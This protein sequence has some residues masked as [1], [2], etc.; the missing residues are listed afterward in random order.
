MQFLAREGVQI[1]KRS[2]WWQ[3]AAQP[4]SDQPDFI[5]GVVEVESTLPPDGLLALLHRIEASFGRVRHVRWEARVLDLD[6][7]D[8]RG[9]NISGDGGGLTLPHPRLQE[10]LFVLLPL[11]EI[12]PDWRHPGSGVG[13][14]TL[15]GQANPIEISKLE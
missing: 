4:V 2:S 5:N 8:Y 3:S 1:L 15:I 14:N 7:I 6:L 11:Q 12:A 13:I 10:R 9:Q